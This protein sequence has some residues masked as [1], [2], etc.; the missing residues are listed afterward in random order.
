[1]TSMD[2]GERESWVQLNFFDQTTLFDFTTAIAAQVD[3]LCCTCGVGNL[4]PFTRI[5]THD[6][7]H[8]EGIVRKLINVFSVT[9]PICA[10]GG[11]QTEAD[12]S[13]GDG[14]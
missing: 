8:I 7:A 6:A 9:Q 5:I 1:V 14:Q 3:C 10:D 11:L 2:G 12:R 4:R 13:G